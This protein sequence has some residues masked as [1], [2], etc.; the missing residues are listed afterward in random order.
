MKFK[1]SNYGLTTIFITMIVSSSFAGMPTKLFGYKLGGPCTKD[2]SLIED[3]REVH[4]VC[5]TTIKQIASIT[6]S[7]KSISYQ[8]IYETT[9]KN[10]GSQPTKRTPNRKETGCLILNPIKQEILGKQKT[11]D[12]NHYHFTG[13]AEWLSIQKTPVYGDPKFKLRIWTTSNF[14]CSDTSF[15]SNIRLSS[16]ELWEQNTMMN[17]E[18]ENTKKQDNL[19]KLFD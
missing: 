8:D 18:K 10:I 19:K 3:D 11:T 1:L 16:N 6:V 5:A 12:P 9:V 17:R 14:G 7:F 4:I 15:M 13:N 2:E